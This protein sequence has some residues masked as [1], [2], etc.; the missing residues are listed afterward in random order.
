MDGQLLGSGQLCKGGTGRGLP[1]LFQPLPH[2]LGVRWEERVSSR[3]RLVQAKC[4]LQGKRLRS[5]DVSQ[6]SKVFE[7]GSEGRGTG[8]EA[9]RGVGISE[10]DWP[11]SDSALGTG[12]NLQGRLGR[13]QEVCV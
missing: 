8:C 12:N 7:G 5:A 6:F 10:I 9:H 11:T 1:R 3:R 13:N 2:S 4:W